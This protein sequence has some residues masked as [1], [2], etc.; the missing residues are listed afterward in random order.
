LCSAPLAARLFF[1][2]GKIPAMTPQVF[3]RQALTSEGMALEA[4]HMRGRRN[5]GH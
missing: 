3:I 2:Q 1:L 5:I 4:P